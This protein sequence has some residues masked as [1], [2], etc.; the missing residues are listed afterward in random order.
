MSL[1]RRRFFLTSLHGLL[2]RGAATLALVA[3]LAGLAGEL[4]LRPGP[5]LEARPLFTLPVQPPF[6]TAD[7][8]G[9][10]WLDWLLHTNNPDYGA[11]FVVWHMQGEGT[12]RKSNSQYY[13]RGDR[14]RGRM[15]LAEDRA[16]RRFQFATSVDE[17]GMVFSQL[18]FAAGS[19]VSRFDTLLA[20]F[21]PNPPGKAGP[22]SITGLP[23]LLPDGRRFLL[24]VYGDFLAWRGV[25]LVD[26]DRP[27]RF[28][29]YPAGSAISAM[30]ELPLLDSLGRGLI[31][32]SGQASNNHNLLGGIPDTCANLLLFDGD[33]GF[34]GRHS[35]TAFKLVSATVFPDQR[36]VLVIGAHSFEPG[37]HSPN[38][39]VWDTWRD[40]LIHAEHAPA[41]P[42]QPLRLG[43]GILWF[44]SEGQVWEA[45]PD[46]PRRQ[47]RYRLDPG[48]DRSNKNLGDCWWSHPVDH[49]GTLRRGSDGRLL[50][51]VELPGYSYR[52]WLEPPLGDRPRRLH[53]LTGLTKVDTAVCLQLE[54]RTFLTRWLQHP[55]IPWS[56]LPG[57]LL[58]LLLLG[59]RMFA[60]ERLLR[61]LV[62]QRGQ[63]VGLLD[64][65]GRL[66]YANDELELLLQE[67]SELPAGLPAK[68]RQDRWQEEGVAKGRRLRWSSQALP[69]RFGSSWTK[70]QV[71]DITHQRENEQQKLF[72]M[73]LAVM[74]HDLKAPLTPLRLQAESIEDALPLLPADAAA[75]VAHALGEIDA[76]V[77]R[78]LQLIVRFMGMA[79]T[80]FELGPVSL[81]DIARAALRELGRQA[82]PALEARLEHD[83]TASWVAEAEGEVLQLALF[84]L[85]QNAAQALDGRGSIVVSLERTLAGGV[86]LLVTDDGPGVPVADLVRVLEPG[87]T[88]R[89]KGTGFGLYFVQRVLERM[90]AALSLR[91]RPE[92][93]LEVRVEFGEPGSVPGTE[94]GREA[95]RTV[96]GA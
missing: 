16:G 84:E 66:V 81:P 88:T 82:W 9:D 26:P 23:R 63:A 70:L 25:L 79:R 69:R 12:N 68:L 7:M 31:L 4:W 15:A 42:Q 89:A 49:P 6:E 18:E 33:R 85:L 74:A 14:I 51:Q 28:R 20:Q 62:P 17:G 76:Q 35:L 43:D 53:L 13:L 78:S 64:H 52:A 50:A 46:A 73:K 80:E 91:N 56:L 11:S 47:R 86:A 75:R 27:E 32:L 30:D 77:E 59:Y 61:R 95:P 29:L 67:P 22:S 71:D 44:D 65:R 36:H 90:G 93:G 19:V 72:L 5:L 1:P 58:F 96:Q 2:L 45:R 41:P 83:G 94:Q 40:R 37:A 10:G 60:Q 55:F 39:L 87:Y 8:D 92:G 57:S 3:L 48:S 34:V 54:S 24:P 21:Q 38:L